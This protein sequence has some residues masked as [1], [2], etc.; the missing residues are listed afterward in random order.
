[1]LENIRYLH[2]LDA[3]SQ[4]GDASYKQLF[5]EEEYKT[6][7][8]LQSLGV[9]EITR[10]SEV[11]HVGTL[12]MNPEAIGSL[13]IPYAVEILGTPHAGKTTMLN[14][15]LEELWLR[16]QRHRVGFVREGA[17]EIKDEYG[18]LRYTDPFMYAMM[19]SNKTYVG[20]ISAMKDINRGM[21]MVVTDRG[22]I[23][24]RVWR[25]TLFS[26]GKVNP[27]IQENEKE[28]MDGLENTPIQVGGIIMLMARKDVSFEHIGGRGRTGPVTNDNFLGSLNEQYW[29][30]HW[31][32]LNGEVPFR[33]YTCI[34]A[35]EDMDTVYGHFKYAMDNALN[36][37]NIFLTALARAFPE[38]YDRIL[39]NRNKDNRSPTQRRLEEML[40]KNIRIVGGDDMTD[41]S[42]ILSRP[43]VE[44]MRVTK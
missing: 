30:L 35:E 17:S 18:D 29:R 9:D 7:T 4:Y 37:H 31:D 20:Y 23:D 33:V 14:R 25:R 36:M 38:E 34:D 39:A 32:I 5:L 11:P 40:G 44:V 19:A 22:Q 27:T 24:R 15:Y 2:V 13:R 41:E 8:A 21:R 12:L 42:D 26:M 43:F 1:M 6:Q 10:P 3:L 16:D 28:F